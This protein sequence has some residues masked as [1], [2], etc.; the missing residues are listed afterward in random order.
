MVAEAPQ[1]AAREKFP[2]GWTI[3]AALALTALAVLGLAWWSGLRRAGDRGAPRLKLDV[4]SASWEEL[5]LVPGIGAHRA[6]NIVEVRDDLGGFESPADLE[7]A[8]GADVAERLGPYV[9][10]A[11]EKP[12]HVEQKD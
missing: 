6:M 1:S 2:A 10:F 12:D 9:T 5:D 4:N 8:L 3:L 11:G 7:A